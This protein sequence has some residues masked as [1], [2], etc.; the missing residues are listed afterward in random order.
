MR[1]WIRFF[2]SLKIAVGLMVLLLVSMAAGTIIES[3]RGTELANRA[4]YGAWWFQTLLAVLGLNVA[5]SLVAHWPW[6]RFRIGYAVTHASVLI[7][8]VGALAT[9][10]FRVEGRLELWEGEESSMILEAGQPGVQGARRSIPLPFFVRLD[11][12]EIDTYPGTQRP[13]MFRSRVTVNDVEGERSFP[14]VIEMNRELSY[15]GYKLFQSSYQQGPERDQTILQVSRDPGQPIVFVG[16][17]LLMTGMV[18]VLSTRIVQRREPAAGAGAMSAGIRAGALTIVALSALW[19]PVALAASVPAGADVA[20]LKALPIQ[21]DGRAMALDTLAREAAWHVTGATMWDGLEPVALVLGWT[22]DPAGWASQPIISV[23]KG[24]LA[25]ALGLPVGTRRASFHDLV[26]S[27]KFQELAES[28][29]AAEGLGQPVQGL[30]K[31]AQ[32]LEERLLWMQ[33]FLDQSSLRVVPPAEGADG[34]WQPPPH[35]HEPSDLVELVKSP[36]AATAPLKA[37]AQREV[38]YNAVRPAR[39]SWWILLGATVISVLAWASGR[40]WLD[41]LALA[42]LI[43][44]FVVM[45]WGIGMR[46]HLAGRVPASN[47]YESMLFLGWGVG[48]FALVAMI[49]MRNRM[50]VLNATAM[51]A[52]TMV[53]ADCLPIDPFIHPVAPVLA[54]TVWLAIHV[55]IIM[56]SYSVLALGVLIAHMQIGCEILAPRR[57]DLSMLMNDLLYWYLE[58]GSILLIAGILTGSMWA[59]SSWGRYWGWDPKEVWSLIA[60]MAYMGILHGRVDRFL[61]RFGVAALS[62]VAFWGIIMTYVGVNFVLTTSLHSYGFAAMG[63]QRWLLIIGAAEVAFLA[64]GLLAQRRLGRDGAA[65]A[66]E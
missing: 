19:G 13:A 3:M 46:W 1:Q 16:Y 34:W 53:L 64:A 55:P 30:L 31:E 20:A 36:P 9:A 33:G 63:V 11:A 35:L 18:V 23:G 41:A 58:I 50:V 65:L 60:F 56:V 54:G 48:L 47:M 22:F 57:R 4:I 5:C 17:I 26:A 12:F 38:L 14:A 45:T 29:R 7:I 61:G 40:R 28:A 2:A 62:I 25:E 32:K 52:L 21:H 24:P 6:G 66:P 27:P 10:L 59:A 51:S 8:L 42:G 43:T 15:G 37:K 39:L 49:F 44:G